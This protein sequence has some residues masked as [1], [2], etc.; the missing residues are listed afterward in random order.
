MALG[1]VEMRILSRV[2]IGRRARSFTTKT[3]PTVPGGGADGLALELGDRL[4]DGD[5]DGLTLALG[6]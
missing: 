5:T 1:V 4:D 6:D 2:T 3:G